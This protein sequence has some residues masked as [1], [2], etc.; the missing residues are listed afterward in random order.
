MRSNTQ[1]SFSKDD[2]NDDDDG[3][4]SDGS[5]GVRRK[6]KCTTNFQQSMKEPAESIADLSRA[7]PVGAKGRGRQSSGG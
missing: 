3:S 4:K 7:S 5:T 2:N 1:S 6:S